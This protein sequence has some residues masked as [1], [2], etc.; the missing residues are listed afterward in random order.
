LFQERHLMPIHPII[1]Q[2]NAAFANIEVELGDQQRDHSIIS[3]RI[4]RYTVIHCKTPDAAADLIGRRAVAVG[5]GNHLK[6]MWQLSGRMRYESSRRKFDV[7]PGDLLVT[8]MAEDYRLEMLEGHEALILIFDPEDDPKWPE[9]ARHALTT[10]ISRQAAI[11]TAAGGVRA[12]LSAPEDRTG[13]FAARTMID[14]ALLS[15]R[16]RDREDDSRRSPLLARA[17]L[18]VLRNSADSRYGPE[19]LARDM[20]MSRRSLYMR[21]AAFGTTPG[22]LIRRTRLDR[23]REDIL[24]D[25]TRSL[26]DIALAN[27][28][29]DGASLS[30]AFRIAYGHAPSELRRED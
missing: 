25:R 16:Q 24:Q 6:L 19:R 14:L 8:S 13:E 21:L 20:G 9:L 11:M 28:F 22:G 23:A 15:T 7:A 4:G 17:A 27:G 29:G 2:A 10:P 12:L 5:L 26:L 3:R 18:H 30:R 1:E